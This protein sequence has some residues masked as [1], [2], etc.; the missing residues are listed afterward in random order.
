[1][2]PRQWKKLN[3]DT[4]TAKDIEARI[5]D[6]SRQYETGWQPDDE[7]PDIG[8]TLGK[9]FAEQMEDNI[10]R[11]NDI[12][13]RYH[14]EFVN[15][16]DI[17]LLPA[18]PSSSIVVMDPVRDTVP[19][20]GVPKGTKL[21]TGDAEPYVFE[22]EHSIYVT[23]SRLVSSFMVDGEEKTV[24]PL[25][26]EFDVPDIYAP[27]E[28]RSAEPDTVATVA[29]PDRESEQEDLL[30]EQAAEAMH[31]ENAGEDAAPE[32]E[33]SLGEAST[34][35]RRSYRFTP[36]TL[37]GR[38]E[39]MGH[40]ALLFYHA[41]L[42]DTEE[43]DLFVRIIDNGGLVEAI[44]AGA[45][46]FR[47]ISAEGI[48]EMDSVT[49]CE[50]GETFLLRKQAKSK[51]VMYGGRRYFMLV[52]EALTP[53]VKAYKVKKILFSARGNAKPPLGVS[54]GVS[55]M[56]VERFA[57]FTDMLSLYAECCI[58]HDV[59]FGKAGAMIT[60]S[61]TLTIEENR[62]S[63]SIEEQQEKLTIIKRRRKAVRNEVFADS[64]VDDMAVEYYNGIGWKRLP[65][66]GDL[67]NLFNGENTGEYSFSFVCPSDWVAN[68][69]GAYEGRC[70]RL[71]II[72]SDN[73]YLRPVVYHYPVLSNVRISYSYE[74]QYMRA[75]RMEGIA[76]TRRFDLST[77][78]YHPKGFVAIHP[79][80]YEKDALYL[81]LS[82]PIASAPAS[83]LFEL[84]D[85]RQYNGLQVYFEYSGKEGF[86]RMKVIDYTEGF[87]RS[88][89]VAFV[90]PSDWTMKELEG[91]R[92]YWLR[93]VRKKAES[94]D[95]N[96]L[97]LPRIKNI[98]LNAV[99]V[100]NIET[101]PTEEVYV[102][103]VVPG[104]R[105]SLGAAGVLDVD[106]WVNE[107]GHYSQERMQIM[108][109]VDPDNVVCEK[110][111][112]GVITAFFVRWSEVDR[113]EASEDPRVYMIDRLTNELIFGDG[114]HTWI[115]QVTTNVAVRFTVRCCDGQAGNVAV[116]SIVDTMEYIPYIDRLANPVKSYGGS[117]IEDLENALERGA[118]ILSSRNRLVTVDD[119]SRAILAYSDNI[120]QVSAIIGEL[121]D[122]RR[123]DSKMSFILLMKEFTE[124]SFAFHR[125]IGSLKNYLLERCELTVTEENL[126]LI[127]PV[128]VD[129]SVNVWVRLVSLND[130]FEIQNIL[131]ECLDEY[132]NPLRGN[133]HDGWT[134]G[135]IP[136]KPQILMRLGI[137][138]S[139]AIVRR[140]SMVASYTDSFGYH[141][142]SL[143]ELVV[144]PFMVCRSGKHE[145]H[146]LD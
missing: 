48:S 36:F 29:A 17:S 23:S 60:V 66:T 93:L 2:S 134:I 77:R 140:S 13:D 22:T 37:F 86:H 27:P 41:S 78:Q 94:V 15:M 99:Q 64:Y 42:F 111:I 63:L 79:F 118:S 133:S 51:A 127:E 43:D 19:G 76:G 55:D 121:E 88:G 59:Y 84:E 14:T 98:M 54:N 40:N 3:I 138:K 73:C 12:L 62:V 115:P 107:M 109:E 117:D 112:M 68:T 44:S 7:N 137:L 75:T 119:F 128:F 101:R 67:R 143:E 131:T 21:L 31:Q 97:I 61:F 69:S 125:V 24:M 90:P 74:E 16:L 135:T 139:R 124:G 141:E 30:E 113:L 81:G 96:V 4:R 58:G 89:V 50:D 72:K 104:M 25:L 10:E 45:M 142:T 106:V 87:V 95:E 70:I 9:L 105:F 56:D 136:K 122:G 47:Y 132:L 65:L 49:L 28:E 103:E 1:M 82:A 145:V 92:C 53:V 110:D 129:I 130:S 123:D 18:K 46:G 20:V 26:G 146:I 34:T 108:Q 144:T 100:S 116:G 120:D 5:A 91:K 80:A 85:S 114:V 126:R 102:E 38:G 6:L 8:T 33:E 71:Q 57:P 35:S 32:E 39:N 11:V 52:L 83:M